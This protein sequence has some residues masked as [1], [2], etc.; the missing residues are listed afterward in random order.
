MGKS[1]LLG[2]PYMCIF[3][4]VVFGGSVEV[5]TDQFLVIACFFTLDSLQNNAFGETNV[6]QQ[7]L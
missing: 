4:L 3:I 7:I 1:Y 6:L 5:L 2:Q